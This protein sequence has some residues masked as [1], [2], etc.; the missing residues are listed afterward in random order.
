LLLLAGLLGIS[1]VLV[2]L[3][4][5]SIMRQTDEAR[6]AAGHEAT[7]LASVIAHVV[8]H[9]HEG[10][11]IYDDQA[12]LQRYVQALHSVE[13]RDVVIVDRGRR[14]LADAIPI[15]KGTLFEI[16]ERLTDKDEDGH[17]TA[18]AGR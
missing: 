11:T 5:F 4:V 15:N 2:G 14:I 8:V 12:A 1:L 3:T 6:A 16:A 10:H 13:R 9:E 18:R 17:A 7:N